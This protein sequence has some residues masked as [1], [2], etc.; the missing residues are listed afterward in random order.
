M[1]PRK[2]PSP[3]YK[4]KALSEE[5]RKLSFPTSP[6]PVN[7]AKFAADAFDK[8]LAGNCHSLDEAFGLDKDRGAPRRLSKA[9]KHLALAKKIFALRLK[10]KTWYQIE[11]ELDMEQRALRRIYKPFRVHLLS[12]KIA[13]DLKH[14]KR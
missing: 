12:S 11:D 2:G 7:L 4:I 1:P 14:P 5:L 13:S 6:I 10:R 9:K 8:F 3:R